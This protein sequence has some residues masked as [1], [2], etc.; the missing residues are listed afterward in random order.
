M[1]FARWIRALEAGEPLPWH[2]PPGTARDFTYA[3]DVV[4]GILA[5]LRRGRAGRAYNLSGWRP[6]PLREA[7]ALVASGH[8]PRLGE[9]PAAAE[10]RVTHGC[11]ERAAAGLGYAPRVGLA[12]GIGRQGRSALPGL[13]LSEGRLPRWTVS[14]WF[15]IFSRCSRTE[16]AS[17]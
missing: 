2:A 4:A 8:E 5:A 11:G 16:I 9:L 6:V 7:L 13:L 12:E 1:A 17:S 10:A 14:V 15:G 3:D